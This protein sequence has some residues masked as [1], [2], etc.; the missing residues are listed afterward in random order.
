MPQVPGRATA[1]RELVRYCGQP[2]LRRL[3]AESSSPER[4]RGRALAVLV[5]WLE[6]GAIAVEAGRAGSLLLDL[7]HLPISHVQLGAMVF[8][9]LET[10]VQEALV[11]HLAPGG[12]LYDI[13]ANVGFFAL[14]GARL[15]GPGDG[16]VYAFEP[17]PASV[18]AIEANAILN[19][20]E[21]IVVIPR[22][23][24]SRPGRARLQ[25]V[26]DQSWSKLEQ[27]GAHPETLQ[28]IEVELVQIDDMLRAEQIRPPT[29][30]KID[31]EGAELAVID[32]M[33]RTL[34]EHHPAIVCELHETQREF[35]PAMAELG[36]RTIN[37]D[38]PGPVRE[39]E[40]NVHALALPADGAGE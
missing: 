1:L 39:A 16:I 24:G 5:R 10:S 20:F 13:G 15:V 32:G 25:L 31:V 7:R 33:R 40:G 8:G 30:I 37:L 9:D 27:Y 36:Y 2:R 12:V 3:R 28:V 11:R 22:A 38:G 34:A 14:F 18:R 35:V 19:G 21:N 17:A 23:V 29:V 26:E 4:W 6:S